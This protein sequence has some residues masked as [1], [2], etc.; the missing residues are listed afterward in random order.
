M[1]AVRGKLSGFALNVPVGEGSLLDL[2]VAYRDAA[3]A[4]D[5]VN[6]LFAAAAAADPR[7]IA[8]TADPIVSSDVHGCTQSILVD[9][10]GTL[11]SGGRLVKVLGWHESLGPRPQH[12]RSGPAI[13]WTR[14]GCGGFGVGRAIMR[15]AINGF[16]RIGRAVF[17]IAE[18]RSGI[19]V[20]AINDL[21]D[22]DML[23]LLAHLRHRDGA[24]RRRCR[25][26]GRRTGDAAR[27]RPHGERGRSVAPA[28]GR[29]GSGCGGGVHRRLPQARADRETPRCRGQTGVAD[30]AGG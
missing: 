26:H 23:A 13:R 12:P 25:N 30:G 10:Q 17:R 11:R 14:L 19:E 8:V 24:L 9:M 29:T 4:A 2:T 18:Q 27:T 21:F 6:D 3:P 1:P 7:R 5:S 20:V 28:L 16:G 22:H 15:V